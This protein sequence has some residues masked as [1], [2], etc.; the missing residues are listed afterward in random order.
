LSLFIRLSSLLLQLL[1]ETSYSFTPRIL[2][3]EMNDE[4]SY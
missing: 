4:I 2:S 3:Q 1:L